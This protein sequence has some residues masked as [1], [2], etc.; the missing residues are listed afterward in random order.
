MQSISW[1]LVDK[2]TSLMVSYCQI[3]SI[4]ERL[5]ILDGFSR[6]LYERLLYYFC[7]EIISTAAAQPAG[8]DDIVSLQFLLEAYTWNI[9]R[10]RDLKIWTSSLGGNLGLQCI[11][12]A[13]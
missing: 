3:K 6:W 9:E 7:G 4:N 8:V 13:L 1:N 5:L 12:P 10:I 2:M 11:L